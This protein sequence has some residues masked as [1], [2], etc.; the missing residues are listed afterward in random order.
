MDPSERYVVVVKE[1]RPTDK[2]LNSSVYPILVLQIGDLLQTTNR[3]NSDWAFG[4]STNSADPGLFPLR[5]TRPLKTLDR[6]EAST[7]NMINRW[8]EKT[9]KAYA[10]GEQEKEFDRKASLISNLT[11]TFEC[12]DGSSSPKDLPAMM[13]RGC[14]FFGMG[15]HLIDKDGQ[16]LRVENYEF[17]DLV[18]LTKQ[19]RLELS[20][21]QSST[22]RNS[23]INTNDQNCS[24]L[25]RINLTLAQQISQI[26]N[27]LVMTFIQEDT[28]L[29]C[30]ESYRIVDLP[31]PSPIFLLLEDFDPGLLGN[32]QIKID[33]FVSKLQSLPGFFIDESQ[34]EVG[35]RT[36]EGGI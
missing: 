3:I 9:M 10:S 24:L 12:Q 14:E 31:N 23:S 6:L 7:I 35:F 28:T 21:R 20:G 32:L 2:L 27:E 26:D 15:L 36:K 33:C 29:P 8:S 25:I 5:F 16:N 13:E 11:S 18:Q 34:H 17:N 19:K 22:S 30:F 1:F 4:C